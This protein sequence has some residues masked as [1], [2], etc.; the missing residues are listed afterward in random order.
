MKDADLP[1]NKEVRDE[2]HCSSLGMSIE[3]ISHE[4]RATAMGMYQALYAIGMFVG[5]FL[6]GVLNSLVGIAAGF[7]FSSV[8][9][10]IATW[11]TLFWNSRDRSYDRH[12][13]LGAGENNI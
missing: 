2:V 3:S 12:P 6:A 11:L 7:Y 4:K 9:G 10:V 5:S 8:L 1:K 13:V